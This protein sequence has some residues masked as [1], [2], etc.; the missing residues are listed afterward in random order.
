MQIINFLGVIFWTFWVYTL[1]NFYPAPYIQRVEQMKTIPVVKSDYLWYYFTTRYYTPVRWQ[2]KYYSWSYE[3]DYSKN[4]MND[5]F[6]TASGHKLVSGDE[7]KIFAC[8]K[9]FER[10]TKL[11]IEGVGIGICEDRGWSI[12]NKRLDIWVGIGDE[13]IKNLASKRASDTLRRV[14]IIRE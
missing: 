10:G 11:N 12:K 7:Y 6:S 5:C 1:G 8:P 3:Q 4:C 9:D 13:W 14:Y 2:K